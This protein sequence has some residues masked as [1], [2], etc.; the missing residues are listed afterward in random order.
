MAKVVVI[1]GCSSG[2]G[3]ATAVLLAKEGNKVYATMRDTGKKEKILAE[4]KKSGT[5]LNVLQLDVTN[6]ESIRTAIGHVID[7]EGRI[8][9][10]INNA[11]Y[12]L[13][14]VAENSSVEQLKAEFEVNLFG[15]FRVT[16]A[17]LPQMRKQKAGHIINI[18]SIAGLRSMPASE[19]YNASKYAVEGL[20]E[21]MAPT[22]KLLG[23]KM[24][25]IEPGPVETD[26][27]SR[28]MQFGNRNVDEPV[29]NSVTEKM[30]A[31]RKERFKDAQKP[32]EIALVI[33]EAINSENPHLRYQT[34][35]WVKENASEKYA[36]L[37]GDA[38]VNGF[39]RRLKNG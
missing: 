10:L 29:Y 28:S 6:D 30:A 21:G 1:T 15:L 18:S 11:G 33:S 7:K 35:E 24:S 2:I 39:V 9:V 8:D 26:F 14:G 12:G 31:S 13:M 32:S 17:V 34:S 16:Q 22:M 20:T 27:N 37:D 4:A 23:I 25:L 5:S 36:N 19:L 38:I 3:L